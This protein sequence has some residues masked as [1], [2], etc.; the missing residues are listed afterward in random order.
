MAK[1][2]LKYTILRV[3]EKIYNTG[4]LVHLQKKLI[5]LFLGICEKSL[6]NWILKICEKILLL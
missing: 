4:F 5:T 1:N 6:K 3:C 2:L